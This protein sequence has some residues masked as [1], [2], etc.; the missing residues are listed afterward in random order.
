MKKTIPAQIENPLQ[1]IQDA[2]ES[3]YDSGPRKKSLLVVGGRHFTRNAYLF[4]PE[5]W[6][7]SN[8]IRGIATPFVG[9]NRTFEKSPRFP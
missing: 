4:G 1:S 9:A 3:L 8:F 2:K 5:D 6:M 7:N